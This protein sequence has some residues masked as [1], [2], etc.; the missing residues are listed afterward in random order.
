MT[1]GWLLESSDVSLTIWHLMLPVSWGPSGVFSHS[2]Y[3][4]AF[5][6]VSYFFPSMVAGFQEQV[7]QKNHGGGALLL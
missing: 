6:A 2:T 5:S 7:S 3:L 4:W 1:R